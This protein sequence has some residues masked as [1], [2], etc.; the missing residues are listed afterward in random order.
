MKPFLG[1]G[2]DILELQTVGKIGRDVLHFL[3]S[4]LK[5][6]HAVIW[7]E[8]RG[9]KLY[10]VQNTFSGFISDVRESV[11]VCLREA[12]CKDRI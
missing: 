1:F 7:P 4:S 3:Q 8:M 2:D 5:C 6:I 10:L 12:W 11:H 9:H